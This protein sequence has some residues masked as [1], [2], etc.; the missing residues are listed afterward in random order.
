MSS[1]NAL[2]DPT[3]DRHSKMPAFKACAVAV[4]RVGGPDAPLGVDAP[5]S[6]TEAHLSERKV[7]VESTPRFLQGVYPFEG[8]GIESP[9][10]LD[11]SLSYQV[12]PG[13]IT[14]PVYFRGGN[15]APELIYLVLMRDGTP[16]RYFPIGAKAD[17]HVPLRVV[18]DLDSGTVLELHVA[19]PDGVSGAVVIDVGLVEV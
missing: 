17:V 14:Q 16:M 8:K 12:P 3:L 19:A 1:A 11:P 2:T 7:S 10:L 18:E 4:R 15:T 13:F 6:P 5:A 9:Y